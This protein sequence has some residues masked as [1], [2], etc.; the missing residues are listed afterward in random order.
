MCQLNQ[1]YPA[2]NRIR[3]RANTRP[4]FCILSRPFILELEYPDFKFKTS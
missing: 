3:I 4:G 2:Q 1:F